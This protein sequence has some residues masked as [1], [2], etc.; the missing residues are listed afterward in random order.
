VA[1]KPPV[2]E[3]KGIRKSSLLDSLHEEVVTL[4]NIPKVIEPL[5]LEKGLQIWKEYTTTHASTDIKAIMDEAKLAVT[6]NQQYLVVSVGSTLL[7]GILEEEQA[8]SS[9]FHQS[10]AN[11]KVFMRI[12]VDSSLKPVE[13]EAPVLNIALTDRE[14]YQKLLTQNVHLETL[15]QKFDLR[16]DEN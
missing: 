6:D 8:L 13:T 2:E 12:E 10:I 9:F 11:D 1:I 5:T 14:K 4:V 3:K 16:F 7:K 15:R